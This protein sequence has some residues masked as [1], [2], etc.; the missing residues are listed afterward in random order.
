MSRSASPEGVSCGGPTLSDPAAPASPDS[1]PTLKY[2]AFQLFTDTRDSATLAEC[3]PPSG[4][5]LESAVSGL[6]ARVGTTGTAT[7]KLG[8]VVGPLCFD[9]SDDG[10]RQL[11][12]DAFRLA[13]THNIAVG[14]HIDDALFWGRRTE[15][16]QPEN[17]EWLDWNATPATGRLDWSSKPTSIMPQLCFNS[18][19]VAAAAEQRAQLIGS[20]ISAHVAQLEQAGQGE[21][22]MGVLLGWETHLGRDFKT[23][24]SSGYHALANRGFSA[25]HP[26][27]DSD[28][29]RVHIVQ[30]YI[31]HWAQALATSG[32]KPDKIYCHIAFRSQIPLTVAALSGQAPST[33][34]YAQTVNFSP[35]S[36]VFD[37]RYQPGFSTYLQTGLQE[38]IREACAQHHTVHWASCEGSAIDPALAEQG[39]R[40][41]AME[42]YLG[43]MFN[44]GAVL[45]NI[46]GWNVGPP[47]NPFRQLAEGDDAVAAYRKFLQGQRLAEEELTTQVPS[48]QFVGKIAELRRLLP[49]FIRTHG[50]AAT[51][52]QYA[53]LNACLDKGRFQDAEQSVDALLETVSAAPPT[54]H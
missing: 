53:R 7:R 26:P 45:V 29:E 32:V 9:N 31:G 12:D 17:L 49:D 34:T 2:L 14:F 11:I 10:I 27:A 28:G 3:F 38:E 44:H 35:A 21:L 19:A 51:Q 43:N 25:A 41:G 22:F 54:T 47:D 37:P 24:R 39:V 46:F 13:R 20:A 15:L 33:E 1:D 18:P 23:G 52:E 36:I 40:G 50:T 6:V 5:E 4:A 48:A 16:N 8:F 30:E 42:P